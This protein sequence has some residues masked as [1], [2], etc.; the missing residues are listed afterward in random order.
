MQLTRIQA[1]AVRRLC[2]QS[3]FELFLEVL[4]S[5]EKGLIDEIVTAGEGAFRSLQ[6]SIRVVR[7]IKSI[8]EKALFII[9]K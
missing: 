8:E 3:D 6:G 7:E 2:V 9:D 4:E 1:L 5:Y